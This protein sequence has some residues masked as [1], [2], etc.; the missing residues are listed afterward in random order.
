[1]T[2]STA[3]TPA[4][5]P[6]PDKANLYVLSDEDMSIKYFSGDADSPPTLSFENTFYDKQYTGEEVEVT[7]TSLGSVVTVY[8]DANPDLNVLTFS[9]LVPD[10]NIEN[11]E[12]EPVTTIGI[13]VN[14]LTSIGGPDLVDGQLKFYEV[15]NLTGT[16]AYD[17][18]F[19]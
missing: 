7:E 17:F 5:P 19:V 11:S 8:V 9:L 15:H 1:M 18:D 13:M 6:G 12:E 14:S 3:A 2:Q 10:V 16:A 4:P